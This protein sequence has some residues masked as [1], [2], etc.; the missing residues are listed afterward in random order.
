MD[1]ISAGVTLLGTKT[2]APVVTAFLDRISIVT[3]V[4][5]KPWQTRRDAEAEADATVTKAE[6]EAKATLIRAE[7][8]QQALTIQE[9][10]EARRATAAVREEKNLS[11]VIGGASDNILNSAQPEKM[12]EDWLANFFDKAKL[13]SDEEMQHLW[14]QVLAGEANVPG[15]FSRRTVNTLADLDKTDAQLFRRM[16]SFCLT[17]DNTSDIILVVAGIASRFRANESF[18]DYG[19]DYGDILSLTEVGLVTFESDSMAIAGQEFSFS[20][21]GR[22]IL[23]KK[24]PDNSGVSIGQV[25]LTKVGHELAHICQPDSD[26][27]FLDYVI[28]RWRKQGHIVEEVPVAAVL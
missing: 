10:A 3:G 18:M 26:K 4:V 19:L 22:Q 27:G 1:I 15:S 13:F 25:K 7:A 16:C 6:A 2:V 21:F 20:Y 12:S 23:V 11:S 5:T 17:E 8:E 9:R 24:T 28:A 14:S